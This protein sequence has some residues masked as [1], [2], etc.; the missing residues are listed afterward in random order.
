L[1]IL[2]ELIG[3]SL[4]QVEQQMDGSLAVAAV[5]VDMNPVETQEQ[6]A[7][8]VEVHHLIEEHSGQVVEMVL[9]LQEHHLLHMSHHSLLHLEEFLV[10]VAAVAVDLEDQRI[11]QIIRNIAQEVVVQVLSLLHTLPK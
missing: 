8:M 10:E 7:D 1:L 6:L 4:D 3:D 9:A 5:V 2:R 11:L